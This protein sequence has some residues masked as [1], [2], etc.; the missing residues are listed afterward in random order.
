LL[1]N[2]KYINFEVKI[3]IKKTCENVKDF[4]T[5][6]LTKIFMQKNK[7]RSSD[8]FLQKLQTTVSIKVTPGSGMPWLSQ[9]CAVFMLGSV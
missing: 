5:E 9:K 1:L 4:L 6:D 8:G 2:I 3:L 7:K